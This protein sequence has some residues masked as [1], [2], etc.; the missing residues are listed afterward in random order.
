[1][2]RS[3]STLLRSVPAALLLAGAM[4]SQAAA[5]DRV[6]L[7]SWDGVRRDV[8]HELLEYQP[9]AEA[10]KACPSND[11]MPK[12]P[13]AC[14]EHWT[15]LPT[16]CSYQ[17]IDSMDVAGKGLTRPQHAQMLTGY[18]P[19]EIG[20]ITNSGRAGVPEGMTVY[21]HLAADRPDVATVHLAGLKFIGEGV[22]SHA[23]DSGAISLLLKR[24]ARDRY[25]G[26][27]TTE[28]VEVGLD[29]LDSWPTFFFFIHYKAP[30]VVAHR[31]GDR[32]RSYRQA[33]INSDVQLGAVMQML[34]DRG[35]LA[36]TKIYVTTDHGFDG[37]FHINRDTPSV[38]ETWMAS[39]THDL[40]PGPATIQDVTP[41]VL[42]AFGVDTSAMRPPYRGVSKL[43]H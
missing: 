4:A 20:D 2:H 22:I 5:A 41:T 18:G 39:L 42:D 38:A 36:G 21:E 30:D 25:T 7:V 14:G 13:V 37:I 12:M 3:L 16:L 23:V 29:Y 40:Q 6:V 33:I 26:S 31:A 8:L 19:E 32:S 43:V 15:C 27:N 35:L 34:S 28:Q 10:P 9:I 17:V 24:G 1:M 11:G